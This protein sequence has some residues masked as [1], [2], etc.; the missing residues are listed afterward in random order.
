[1]ASYKL[2]F[3][4]SVAKDLRT[5]PKVDVRK[6]LDRQKALAEDPRAAGCKKLSGKALYRARQGDYR[7]IYEI[8]DDRLIV[9]IIKIGHR[10]KACR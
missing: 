6:I 2:F 7:I 3:K 4:K 8:F 10:S 5:L 1:M 9:H